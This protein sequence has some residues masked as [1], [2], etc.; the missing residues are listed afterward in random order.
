MCVRA[1]VCAYVCVHIH[2]CVC[3]HV[4]MC[5]DGSNNSASAKSPVARE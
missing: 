1:H 4:C 5:V 3:V 2:V